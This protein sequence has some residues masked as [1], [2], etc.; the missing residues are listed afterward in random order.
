MKKNVPLFLCMALSFFFVQQASAQKGS[1][2]E[3][4]VGFRV[5]FGDG[6]TFAGVTGKHFF[7]DNI[8]GEAMVLFGDHATLVE[9]ELQYH[10]DIANAAGLKWLI[11]FGPGFIFGGGTTNVLLRPLAGLDYK[12]QDVPINFT[13]DWRPAFQITHGSDFT[14]AR[15]GL[16]IRYA[17]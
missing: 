2:Y 1:S 14:A 16:G 15:F 6:T 5:D 4:A 3:N 17:W 8:A 10:G 13:F 9:P 11:G 12:I 7:S